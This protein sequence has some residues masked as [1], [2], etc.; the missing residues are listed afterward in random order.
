MGLKEAA[1]LFALSAAA[2]EGSTAYMRKHGG[3]ESG[4]VFGPMP[5][6]TRLIIKGSMF[7][8]Y[9]VAQKKSKVVRFG[10]PAAFLFVGAMNVQV[11]REMKR[12]KEGR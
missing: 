5:T 11:A 8:L 1:L 10:V 9:L 12:R 3:V 4:G 7:P 6:R 2:D